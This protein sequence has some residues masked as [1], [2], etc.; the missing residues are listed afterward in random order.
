MRLVRKATKQPVHVGSTVTL[1]HD[2]DEDEY[3]ITYMPEP[4]KP[5]SSG[6]VTAKSCV[7]NHERTLYAGSWGLEWIER[8]DRE[9][10]DED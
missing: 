8:E 6:K 3:V 7:D 4:H 10:L 1:E 5:E 9:E 2:D